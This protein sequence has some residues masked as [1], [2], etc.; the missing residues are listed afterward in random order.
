[1]VNCRSEYCKKRIYDEE[2]VLKCSLCMNVYHFECSNFG[3][4]LRT[5]SPEL[6]KFA[7]DIVKQFKIWLCVYCDVKSVKVIEGKVLKGL[8]A[9]EEKLSSINEKIDKLQASKID[10]EGK[11]DEENNSTWSEV[12]KKKKRNN[13]KKIIVTAK[14]ADDDIRTSLM[15]IPKVERMN[16]IDTKFFKKNCVKIEF[17]EPSPSNSFSN[18]V[19]KNVKDC[20]IKE[21]K[22]DRPRIKIKSIRMN[23]DDVKDEWKG[24]KIATENNKKV[25]CKAL[26][27]ANE[28]LKDDENAKVVF[29]YEKKDKYPDKNG[30]EKLLDVIMEVSTET[31]NHFIVD[32]RRFLYNL[33]ACRVEPSIHIKRCRG[34]LEFGHSKHECEK[35]KLRCSK[36]A[37]YGHLKKDCKSNEKCCINCKNINEK[38]PEKKPIKADHDAFSAECP[39]FKDLNAKMWERHR[40]MFN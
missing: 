10:E 32:K 13:T 35:K 26:M 9:I 37:M 14:E 19:K 39:V 17:E 34:C 12:V 4:S 30:D 3:P 29:A 21:L 2:N 18:V 33:R 28:K 27:N 16:V 25:L 5:A 8:D 1:M 38:H 11:S 24:D 7:W 20:T 31:Y 23:F 22:G 6:K 15:K 40:K 36:C